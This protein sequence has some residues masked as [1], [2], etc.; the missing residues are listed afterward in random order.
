MDE[1]FNNYIKKENSFLI[2]DNNFL[3]KNKQIIINEIEKNLKINDNVISSYKEIFNNNN[4]NNNKLEEIFSKTIFNQDDMNII[5]LKKENN[6]KN[7]QYINLFINEKIL[8]EKNINNIEFS[9]IEID[10]ESAKIFK[11]V[12]KKSITNLN[13]FK[14]PERKLENKSLDYFEFKLNFNNSEN[15]SYIKYYIIYKNFDKILYFLSDKKKENDIKILIEKINIFTEFQDEYLKK[16]NL[17]PSIQNK[18]LMNIEEY[19]IECM[20]Y[21]NNIIKQIEDFKNNLNNEDIKKYYDDFLFKQNEFVKKHEN[22]KV[23]EIESYKNLLQ[24]YISNEDNIINSNLNYESL[25]DLISQLNITN[26]EIKNICNKYNFINKDKKYI[27]ES[28]NKEET[29]KNLE[30]NIIEKKK[31]TT[32][33][34]KNS[35]KVI[36]GRSISIGINRFENNEYTDISNANKEIKNLK[37]KINELIKIKNEYQVIK[38]DNINLKNENNKLLLEIENLKKSNNNNININSNVKEKENKKFF[39]II[40]SRN[41]INNNKFN[42]SYINPESLLLL[43]KIQDEN[44]E[45]VNQLNYFRNKNKELENEILLIKKINNNSSITTETL[46]SNVSS[47]RNRSSSAKHEKRNN[48]KVYSNM[49]KFNLSASCKNIEK[50]SKNK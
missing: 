33:N 36:K 35:K 29:N 2:F 3:D 8:N 21:Y 31:L 50:S 17:F 4:E 10:L 44:K 18:I 16:I 47:C 24:Y 38:Q 22:N 6:N 30:K 49:K 14:I 23:K 28:K 9:F 48:N 40:T 32:I 37:V 1:I 7:Y 19:K 46:S 27:N 34:Q 15:I 11:N 45:I 12:I 25:K 26:Q 13:Q 5:Y 39:K 20:E 41:K 42:S 43:K